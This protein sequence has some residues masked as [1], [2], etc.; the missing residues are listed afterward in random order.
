MFDKIKEMNKLRQLQSAIKKEKVKTG[1]EGTEVVMRGDFAVISITLNPELPVKQ[2]EDVL[3]DL[4][5]EARK[6]MQSTIQEKFSG[7]MPSF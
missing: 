2:Q 4:L 6:K 1:K 3:I 7:Q 5:S